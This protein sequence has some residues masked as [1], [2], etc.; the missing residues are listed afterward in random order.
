MK[1]HYDLLSPY[2]Q[3]LWGIHLHHGYWITG[4]ETKEAAQ[5]NLIRVLIEKAKL[6]KPTQAK[7]PLKILDVGCGIGGSSIYLAKHLQALVTGITISPVQVQMAQQLAKEASVEVSFQVMDAEKMSFTETFDVIW[8]VEAL[9]H[10]NNPQLFFQ[11]AEKILRPGGKFAII[12]WFKKEG[13][14]PQ[15]EQQFIQP[16]RTGMLTPHMTT[17]GKYKDYIEA[18]GIKVTEFLD[19]S[20]NVKKSWD[21]SLD[22]IKNPKFWKL[23][24]ANGKD[25]MQFLQAFKAMRDGFAS[26]NFV[27]G[28]LVGEKKF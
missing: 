7:S 1:R 15:Q 17:M 22:I 24:M 5:E 19:L 2:Y 21:I 6:D 25:F 12:D 18:G 26:K 8:S 16:I 9:S 28:L 13:L 3:S 10:L 11:Q 14:T 4:K 23:A 20:E 27:Y